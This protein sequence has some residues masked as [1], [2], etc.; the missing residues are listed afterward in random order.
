MSTHSQVKSKALND[1]KALIEGMKAF[2]PE[3]I[4]AQEGKK[5]EVT[6]DAN[7]KNVTMHGSERAAC[8]HGTINFSDTRYNVGINVGDDGEVTMDY[9]SWV[10]GGMLR[11]RLHGTTM[12]RVNKEPANAKVAAS[13]WKAK[14]AARKK[15]K[16]LRTKIK[17][18]KLLAFVPAG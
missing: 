1:A 12:G 16:T 17:G 14:Q 15:G 2:L 6:Y 4:E 7:A 9:D 13:Y 5:V 3:M 8:N 18:D 11:K 10:D